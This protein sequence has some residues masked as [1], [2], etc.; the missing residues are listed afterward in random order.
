[1]ESRQF[2]FDVDTD[3]VKLV[4]VEQRG[5]RIDISVR[6]AADVVLDEASYRIG[7]AIGAR[8]EADEVGLLVTWRQPVVPGLDWLTVE[9]TR[10]F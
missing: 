4:G 8:F 9:R 1:M 10:R 6:Y 5:R 7:N 3:T 2:T